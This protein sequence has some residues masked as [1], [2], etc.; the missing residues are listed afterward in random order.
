MSAGVCPGRAAPRRLYLL[1]LGGGHAHWS[2][3][4]RL[5][6][7]ALEGIFLIPKFLGSHGG[8]TTVARGNIN[9]M[10]GGLETRM[11]ENDKEKN[12][13]YCLKATRSPEIK[14]FL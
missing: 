12:Y 7:R 4:V 6:A 11:L 8:K 9:K 1:Q 3:R 14:S 13:K 2:A 5:R 10:S